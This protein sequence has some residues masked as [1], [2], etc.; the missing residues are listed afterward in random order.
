MSTVDL[1]VLGNGMFGA[2]LDSR[3][4]FVWCCMDA[5][6]GDPIFNCLVNNNSEQTGFYDVVLEG[7]ERSEQKY[8]GASTVLVTTLHSDQG[9]S[10][11][12][13]DFAPRFSHYDRIF[14]PFQVMRT[15]VRLKGDPRVSIRIRPT[16]QYNSTD[17]YQTRGSQHVRF[18][19]PT[20]TWRVTTNTSIRHILEEVPF[21]LPKDPVYIVFGSDESFANSLR[22]VIVDFETKTIRYWKEWCDRMCLPVEFQNVLV[23]A[24]MT[25]SMLQSED[26]G[27]FLSGFTMSLPLGPYGEAT[28]DARVCRL[29][30]ECLAMPVLRDC[31]LFDCCRK[32]LTFAKEVCFQERI[33]QHSYQAWGGSAWKPREFAPY[34]AGFRGM[35]D[36]FT[37]GSL[38][39][40]GGVSDS[41]DGTVVSC[42]L[43]VALAHAFFDF[44]LSEEICTSKLLEKLENYTHQAYA[45]F[46]KM[47]RAYKEGSDE[48]DGPA[49]VDVSA[50][51][52]QLSGS[53]FFDDDVGFL[54]FNHTA[55]NDSGSGPVA[56]AASAAAQGPRIHTLSSALCWAAA[57]RLH[58][59]VLHYSADS[60]KA[61][62]WQQRAQEM[63]EE[64]CRYAWNARRGGFTT[65]W[66]G[67]V[68][69]P[70]TLRL[71]ELGLLR[72][73]DDRF[74]GT[75]RAF[76]AD[77]LGYSVC[78]GT[79]PDSLGQV[80]KE[81]EDTAPSA[82]FLTNTLLWYCEA[83]RSSGADA[84]SRRLLE[85]LLRCCTHRGILSESVD[86]KNA[87]P[88]GN[89]PSL[90]ALLSLLR[91]APRLSRS[92]R[93]V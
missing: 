7:C 26:S 25:V 93:E 60:Q 1:A 84:Q 2:L 83:L 89:S 75:V 44:R 8:L 16:F 19:G 81:C 17:G 40:D 52:A 27:G 32:F 38:S 45:S 79:R 76:E 21:L 91:V 64:I 28:R 88:W 24:A 53:A 13:R 10:I 85:A 77:A 65:H 6:D 20:L 54:V 4:R 48:K 90:A 55:N 68:V 9:D 57:D 12:I 39:D 18:C 61:A 59:I 36:V 47:V 49:K 34:L 14:R 56:A 58:R 92:W 71:A 43:V 73:T 72:A 80:P 50:Q 74:R 29:L 66:G 35:G 3:A 82:C 78:L 46:G 42:L 22:D 41:G 31:G 69:G 23:R 63:R 87:E 70:S 67:N 37:G 86:L 62:Y 33:P 30:D 15:I 5:F 51:K 11:E